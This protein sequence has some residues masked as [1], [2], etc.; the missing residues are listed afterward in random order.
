MD[1][2]EEELKLPIV[3][4]NNNSLVPQ[5]E[6]E[7]PLAFPDLALNSILS[8]VDYYLDPENAEYLSIPEEVPELATHPFLTEDRELAFTLM[9]E[10]I[11]SAIEF[12]KQML[13]SLKG[14]ICPYQRTLH[15]YLGP[16]HKYPT[17]YELPIHKTF[18]YPVVYEKISTFQNQVEEN[19]FQQLDVMVKEA[20]DTAFP[21]ITSQNLGN[22]FSVLSGNEYVIDKEK[23]RK[24][25]EFGEIVRN[26]PQDYIDNHPYLTAF[27][28]LSRYSDIMLT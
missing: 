12:N 5:P 11:L 28:L 20:A 7:Y 15:E 13:E 24:H 16:N 14:P 8:G 25:L 6:Q 21:G 27:K 9:N 10:L 19:M 17:I 1:K 22:A 3:P 2:S 23:L 18:S 4:A 26:I